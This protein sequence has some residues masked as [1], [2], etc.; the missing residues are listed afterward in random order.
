M[1]IRIV[2]IEF[3][4]V[5][6]SKRNLVGRFQKIVA[7][8]A[9]QFATINRDRAKLDLF[10]STL[11]N[12]PLGNRGTCTQLGQEFAHPCGTCSQFYGRDPWPIISIF[13][14][15]EQIITTCLVDIHRRSRVF[16]TDQHIWLWYTP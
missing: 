1:A 6:I 11:R 8:N 4:V 12:Q 16:Q 15:N 7:F 10:S 3:F 5:L 9:A 13:A 14:A 2:P